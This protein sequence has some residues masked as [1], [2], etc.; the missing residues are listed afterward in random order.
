MVIES[1]Q[2]TG[3]VGPVP[4]AAQSEIKPDGLLLYVAQAIYEPGTSPLST[5][6]PLVAP[7]TDEV[8]CIEQ[9]SP[10]DVFERLV[11]KR[12]TRNVRSSVEE[13]DM[14]P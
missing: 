13:V 1:S 4:R 9:S 3:P 12:A 5:W 7:A 2:S 8:E 10:L 14:H 6:V 11:K